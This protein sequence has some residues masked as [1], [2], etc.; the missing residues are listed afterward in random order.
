MAT[1]SMF[2]KI[3]KLG[4]SWHALCSATSLWLPSCVFSLVS[5]SSGIS[6]PFHGH[7]AFLLGHHTATFVSVG[8][9]SMTSTNSSST[10]WV[11][12]L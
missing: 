7:F 5:R 9:F 8:V 10:Y 6:V 2:A 1:T 12:P 11:T 4:T 3:R